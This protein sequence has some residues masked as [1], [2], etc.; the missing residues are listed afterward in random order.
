MTNNI[1]LGNKDN[2]S[3]CNDEIKHG[4]TLPAVTTICLCSHDKCTGIYEDITHSFELRCCL[5]L[6]WAVRFKEVIKMASLSTYRTGGD[7]S[8]PND[9]VRSCRICACNGFPHEPIIWKETRESD[10]HIVAVA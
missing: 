9:R 1:D 7:G 3:P 5:S 4:I 10:N 2:D 6:S 8:L